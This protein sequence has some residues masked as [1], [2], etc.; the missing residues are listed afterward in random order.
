VPEAVAANVRNRTH[1]ILAQAT[2]PEE[3]LVHGVLLAF[4][5]AL[6]GF[7]FHVINGQLRYVHNLYGRDRHVVNSAAPLT[8]GPHRLSFRYEST[9][10][11]GVGTLL[12]DDEI[13]GTGPIA[14]F[15]PARFNVHGAGLTLPLHRGTALGDGHPRVSTAAGR[16][17]GPVRRHHGRTVTGANRNQATAPALVALGTSTRRPVETS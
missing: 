4:G 13:V 3:G 6:G 11:G 15:T 9:G 1:E 10:P 2:V 16:A 8:P 17:H 14:R 7:S 12:I 5:S